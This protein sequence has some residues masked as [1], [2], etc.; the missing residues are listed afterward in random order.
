M[1][2]YFNIII[3]ESPKY[4]P[5]KIFTNCQKTVT[6]SRD[7]SAKTHARQRAQTHK[8]NETCKKK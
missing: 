5:I 7:V 2:I 6:L 1:N 4:I 8:K 3:I